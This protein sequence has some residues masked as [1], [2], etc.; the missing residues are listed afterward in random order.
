[1]PHIEA[2][3]HPKHQ[4]TSGSSGQL[5]AAAYLARSA[6][7]R[8]NTM[9][10]N[11][12]VDCHCHLFN[13]VDI[14]LYATLQGK[15]EMGTLKRLVGSFAVGGA[16]LAGVGDNI[17]EGKEE[18]IRFFERS[19][20]DNIKWLSLQVRNTAPDKN[21]LMTPLVMDFD[22]VHQVSD[23]SLNEPT[24]EDQLNRLLTAIHNTKNSCHNVSFCPFIGFDL[25]KLDEPKEKI[26]LLKMQ[27]LWKTYGTT[28]KERSTEPL[29]SGSVF[30][31]KLYPPIG[32]NPN[33]LENDKK[34][35]YIE[36]YEWCCKENIPLTTH[37]QGA[38]GSFSVG[39]KSRVVN[40]ITHGKNWWHL[41]ETNPEI[42]NLRI[43]FAHFGGEEGIE[44]L[45]DWLGVDKD[46]WT[47]YLI[48]LLKKFPN[49][50]ADISAYDFSD[51]D[52][53]E[54]L[55]KLLEKDAEGSFNE[56]GKYELS[57]KLLWGSDVPM[58]ISSN[59]YR[60][61]GS[62]NGISEYKHLYRKFEETVSISKKMTSDNPSAFLTLSE[63]KK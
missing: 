33:P 63:K 16:L 27:E 40:K 18:F 5:E 42:K 10:N 41:F 44:D 49:T 21:I 4:L 19:I 47:F 11:L 12:F 37:C 61:G 60:K 29:K 32:F 26:G 50:Y 36:F 14:P 57:G 56:E 45:I 8:R 52:A 58:V 24:V 7:K 53:C 23:S 48:K 35:R 9:T 62:K 28:S 2:L 15:V 25:R 13:I 1:M 39:K 54:N 31:I 20:E 30:G 59:A 38:S 6:S 43:N 51:S 34:K 55:I 17:L 3:S 46:S 22:P